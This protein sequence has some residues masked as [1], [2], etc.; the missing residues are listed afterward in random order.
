VTVEQVVVEL[1]TVTSSV[2]V[3][4]ERVR[5]VVHNNTHGL[6][7]SCST[8]QRQRLRHYKNV[9]VVYRNSSS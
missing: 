2:G 4:G 9:I 6:S 1:V 3:N 7:L 8:P 5:N